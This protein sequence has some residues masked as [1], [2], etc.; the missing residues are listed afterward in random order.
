MLRRS[1]DTIA[2]SAPMMESL[3]DRQLMAVSTDKIIAVKVA[4]V[5]DSNN[6]ATGANR[7]TIGFTSNITLANASL[8]R[9]F[10]YATDLTN[11]G[12]K[13]VTV[14]MTISAS[15]NVLTI[16]TDRLI[17]KGSRLFIYNGAITDTAGNSVV[18][19]ASTAA[20]TITFTVGQN[21]PRYT[22][23]SRAFRPTDYSYFDPSG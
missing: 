15:A 7:I 9:S 22:L 6:I 18:F 1:H 20:N 4:K 12:Q 21:K 11:G 5:A 19:D 2:L 14:G 16:I 23:S 10:G 13:K 8:I 17:R 3:E